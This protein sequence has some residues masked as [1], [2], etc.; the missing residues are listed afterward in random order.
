MKPSLPKIEPA[1]PPIEISYQGR[2]ETYLGM[3][4]EILR[5]KHYGYKTEKSYLYWIKMFL[6]FLK[7]QSV[8]HFNEKGVVQ[9]FNYLALE[10]N[11]AESTQNQALCALSFFFKNV[12]H[13]P[14]GELKE[15]IWS[16]RPKQLPV[17]FT[18][19]EKKYPQ[20]GKTWG[21]FWV[22]PAQNLS[23]DPRSG[24]R[25]RHHI[26]ESGVQRA[27]KVAIRKAG[28]VK[29]AGCHTFR[30]SFATHLLENGYD[31]RTVQELLGHKDVRTTMVY[32]HVLNKGGFGVK[33]PLD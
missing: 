15:L 1:N 2:D 14:L 24:I 19:L 30:H 13:Q 33:S 20:A 7:N 31:I 27:V 17:V 32:T 8:P 26:H 18:K 25:R 11:V 3:A 6:S 4:Q 23:E 10:R 9:F 12:L 21:W 5:M 28:I 16:K 22:F 29:H